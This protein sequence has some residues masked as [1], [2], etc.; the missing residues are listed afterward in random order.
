MIYNIISYH[1]IY[2]TSVLCAMIC[3]KILISASFAASSRGRSFGL[4]STTDL[5]LRVSKFLNKI[6]K[7]GIHS[8]SSSDGKN[9]LLY[10]YDRFE[11]THA[12]GTNGGW[13]LMHTASEESSSN[14]VASSNVSHDAE[15]LETLTIR[16]I[17]IINT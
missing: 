2:D 11:H 13:V 9:R 7:H 10:T 15:L 17:S 12:D 4:R 1:I 16:K 14:K 3:T 6:V 8:V 5:A